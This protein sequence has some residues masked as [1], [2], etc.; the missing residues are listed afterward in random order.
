MSFKEKKRKRKQSKEKQ[1][2]N[3]NFYER[4]NRKIAGKHGQ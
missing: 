1:V 2:G 3:G 4:Q